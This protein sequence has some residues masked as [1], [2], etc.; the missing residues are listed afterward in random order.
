[1]K[2]ESHDLTFHWRT[3]NRSLVLAG[4]IGLSFCIHALA[5]YIFQVNYPAAVSIAPPPVQVT[6]LSPS[7]PEYESLRR[8]I[9]A[10]NPARVI[11]PPETTPP[12]L[13]N[14]S[15][16]PSTLRAQPKLADEKN[17]PVR[18]PAAIPRFPRMTETGPVAIVEPAKSNSPSSLRLSG[19]LADRKPSHSISIQPTQ[20]SLIPLKP[21]RFMAGINDRGEVRYLFLEESS[22]DKALDQWAE[23]HLASLDFSHDTSPLTWGEATYFWGNNAYSTP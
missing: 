8:W 4:F 6:L 13:G 5:L 21:S 3:K 11:S 15:Y 19:A 2:S 23:R 16:K 7:T 20:K 1:M 17:E 18:F 10:V 12:N 14:I 22:G 9:E